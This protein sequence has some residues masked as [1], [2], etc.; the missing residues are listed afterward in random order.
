MHQSH[1]SIGENLAVVPE[2]DE[3]LAARA[4]LDADAF[5]ELYRRYI[6]HV[7]GYCL[8]RLGDRQRAEDC[9][10]QIFIKVIQSLPRYRPDRFRSWLFTIAHNEVVDQ[11]RQ[12]RPSLSLEDAEYVPSPESATDELVEHSLAIGELRQHLLKLPIAQRSVIELRLAGLT[13]PE[14]SES[15]GKSAAWT[16]TTQY[17]AIRELRRLMHVAD[18]GGEA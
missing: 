6:D 8:I 4:A 14:I 7:F 18:P 17:R 13:G 10:S 5:T 15:L 9:T 1:A 2:T 3:S 16:H 11:H 12:L